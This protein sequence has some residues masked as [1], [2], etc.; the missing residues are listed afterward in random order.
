MAAI[1][2]DGRCD[3]SKTPAISSY[4]YRALHPFLEMDPH[5]RSRTTSGSQYPID[6]SCRIRDTTSTRADHS[7]ITIRFIVDVDLL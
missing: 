2:L 6:R 5:K 4:L 1:F 7:Q 3:E